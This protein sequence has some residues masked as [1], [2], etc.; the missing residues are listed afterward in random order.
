MP[1]AEYLKS[2]GIEKEEGEEHGLV[3]PHFRQWACSGGT[4]LSSPTPW[5][6]HAWSTAPKLLARARSWGSIAH[7]LAAVSSTVSINPGTQ[8]HYKL[9]DAVSQLLH[10]LLTSC[11]QKSFPSSL[12]VEGC[13]WLT[14]WNP[15][16]IRNLHKVQNQTLMSPELLVFHSFIH[17]ISML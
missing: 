5:I 7:L 15:G 8:D 16:D 10:Y 1:C 11:N 17:P 13:S 9:R 12:W 2:H 3:V 6:V 14:S 4:P